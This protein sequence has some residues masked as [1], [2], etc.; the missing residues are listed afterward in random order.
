MVYTQV[1]GHKPLKTLMETISEHP[2][3][4][5]PWL[6]SKLKTAPRWKHLPKQI[7]FSFFVQEWWNVARESHWSI[8]ESNHTRTQTLTR[9]ANGLQALSS[10][11]PQP[12]HLPNFWTE[13]NRRIQPHVHGLPHAPFLWLMFLCF[14]PSPVFFQCII[15]YIKFWM[16]FNVFLRVEDTISEPILE[17]KNGIAAKNFRF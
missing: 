7:P 11:V 13:L 14:K 8:N 1:G 12:S 15:E 16:I 5:T 9:R 6:D 10:S 17:P 2:G 3:W 4:G